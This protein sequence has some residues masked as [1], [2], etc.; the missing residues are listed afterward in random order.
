MRQ[1][2]NR[3][4]SRKIT[5][6][7]A[8]ALIATI[9]ILVLLALISVGL[10][11]L[12]TITVRASKTNKDKMVAQANAK[13]AL[14]IALGELQKYAGPDQRVTG[15]S[16]IKGASI[17]QRNWTGVW[18]TEEDSTLPV[19]LVSGNETLGIPG[20]DELSTYPA[21]Y[22]EPDNPGSANSSY[23]I[24][25]GI[26]TSDNVSVPLVDI[27]EEG[28]RTG[29]Y[30]YWVSDEGSKARVDIE[31]SDTDES[32][33]SSN[34]LAQERILRSHL[35]RRA[36][37]SGISDTFEPI[38]GPDTTVNVG[39]LVSLQTLDLAF[40]DQ[41]VS[42]KYAHD[43]TVGGYGLPVNVAEGGMKKDLS[44]IFDY[45]QQRNAKL[46]NATIGATPRRTNTP[47][48]FKFER[49]GDPELFVLSP[50]LAEAS[51][52]GPNFGILYNYAQLWKNLDEGVAKRQFLTPG[53]G[54]DFRSNDWAPY[55]EHIGKG[56]VE[57]IFRKDVQHYNSSVSPVLSMLQMGMRLRSKK[58]TVPAQK[59]GG[60]SVT[61]YQLQVEMKPLIGIWNP[62]NVK[63]APA[64]YQVLW[65]VYPTVKLG[66]DRQDGDEYFFLFS[67]GHNDSNKSVTGNNLQ[68]SIW[69]REIWKKGGLSSGTYIK[70]FTDEIDFEPGEIRL[71]S[72]TA[73]GDLRAENKLGSGWND[74]AGFLY[75]M[76]VSEKDENRSIVD[77]GIAGKKLI[78]EPGSKVWY[79]NAY[80]EDTQNGLT[81]KYFETN[82][83]DGVSSSWVGF[84]NTHRM[85]D[86]WA[87][88]KSSERQGLEYLVPEQIVSKFQQTGGKETAEKRRV[89]R[90]A[91]SP[92]HIAT[93]RFYSRNTTDASKSL[94]NAG[95]QRI[96]GW[97]DTNPRFATTSAFWDGSRVTGNAIP[98]EGWHFATPFIGANY[99]FDE[100]DPQGDGGPPGRGKIAEGQNEAPS[101][102]Q[103][104][105]AGGRYRGYGGLSSGATGQTHVTLFDVPRAPLVSLGQFQHAQ[106]SRYGYEP[107]FPFGNSYASLRVP[108][109]K[110]FV[111]DFNDIDDFRMVDLSYSLNESLWDGYFFSTIGIDYI[112]EKETRD[113]DLYL[114][115]DELAS[116][117]RDLPNPRHR[118]IPRGG[119]TSFGSIIED[120][121][122]L[123]SEA[124]AARIGIEGAFNVNSTSEEAWKA[125]LSSMANFEFP[126]IDMDGKVAWEESDAIRFPRFGH[127]LQ[128][129][130]W[131]PSSTG[132]HPA[133]WQGFRELSSDEL[134]G[135]ASSIVAEVRARGPFRSMA[136]FVNRDPKASSR[137]E[138]QRKGALQ[139]AI[140]NV[141][142]EKLDSSVGEVA[143]QPEGDDFS[144]VIENGDHQ[145]A[146]YSGFLLQGDVLQSL[147]PVLS[148]RS[149]YFRIR[150]AGQSVDAQGQVKATAVCEAYVQ[151]VADYADA[152]DEAHIPEVDLS[153]AMN[154][155]FGRRFEIVS[156]RWVD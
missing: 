45:S 136:D 74:D 25:E 149:D 14:M 57:E 87:T 93:W 10:L 97:I 75:D 107:S 29:K 112:G 135:L 43:L 21:G 65:S 4:S 120:A 89:E 39:S 106:L 46:L 50:E 71:F 7:P 141:V 19:W 146:G 63:I 1:T 126:V 2:F 133:F 67:D 3:R 83:K 118:F 100:D 96:R 15:S 143:Q 26:N 76:V 147:A 150:A 119:E 102:P 22:Y 92:Y 129:D 98:Y 61:G 56:D 91:R 86:L 47:G 13:L 140:D 36:G 16:G 148:V 42:A 134:D 35:P 58:V 101:F 122:P 103:A 8:F 51:A 121:G 37:L 6:Q 130:G 32:D 123:A 23:M 125:V 17:A 95:S 24:F 77:S 31:V 62:Y 88:P 54:A 110:T 52:V 49:V 116:G 44:L 34:E 132:D 124:I 72:V 142:N 41:N 105:N 66:I 108:L 70:M 153:S 115:F 12:S 156:F 117:S 85:G 78:L 53:I 68:P 109:G 73:A 55:T 79:G 104:D 28:N 111:D 20:L 99:E 127:V 60:E 18:S 94:N 38:S 137:K 9:S 84:Q 139:S 11:S 40:D 138:S 154:K 114:P 64:V 27:F 30:A 151:R 82:L 155:E 80:L 145:A 144:D 48:L 59:P 113:L 90:L 152:S 5:L 131:G 81:R 69:L 128:K 33:K